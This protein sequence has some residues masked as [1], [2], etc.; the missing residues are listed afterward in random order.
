MT[1]LA[2]LSATAAVAFAA[3]LLGFAV[4][5]RV[6]VARLARRFPPR[7]DRLPTASAARGPIHGVR[8]P[9][10]PEADATAAPLVFLHGAMTNLEDLRAP[11]E[12][13]LA[14]SRTLLFLDR[15]GL[16][17]SGPRADGASTPDRQ[18]RAVADVLDGLATPPAILVAHSYGAAVALAL[19]L[20]RPDRVAGLA[21]LAPA[22]HPWPGGVKRR[23]R[24]L[25]TPLAGRLLAHTVVTPFADATLES[26]VA[27]SF[28]P[29]APPRD[30]V[31]RTA[32]PLGYR[33]RDIRNNARDIVDL[34][35]AVIAAR[36]RYPEIAVPTVVVTADADA[37][38]WPLIHAEGLGHDLPDVSIV[39]APGAGHNVHHTATD[40]V[41]AAIEG[42][43]RRVE[44]SARLA[45]IGSGADGPADPSA[46]IALTPPVA[47]SAAPSAPRPDRP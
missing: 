39:R 10:C 34:E 21:L 29:A 25:A 22:S 43:A 5:T 31:R 8:R 18:A 4:Y 13:R 41:V 17:W 35:A 12:A 44:A 16:G 6:R 38:L 33:P 36:P 30:Y 45:G 3:I 32:L 14:G 20:D 1:I 28:A 27:G 19:A 7:G 46:A 11:L 37:V 15:P 2:T 26:A 40:T 42:L 24:L 47:D 23:Y 9:P